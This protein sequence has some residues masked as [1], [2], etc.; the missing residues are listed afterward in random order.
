MAAPSYAPAERPIVPL[1]GRK[2]EARPF[3]LLGQYKGTL[4]LLE[5]PD[6]LYVIDQ[7]VA[8]ER[9]LY[10]R[11]RRSLAK[12]GTPSQ[13]LFTPALLDL[14]PAER[15]RLAELEAAAARVRA[16]EQRKRRRLAAGLAAA[17]EARRRSPE[18]PVTVLERSG[19]ISYGA[20]GLPY[21]FA[22]RIPS[23]EHLVLH[24][25]EYFRESHGVE[26]RLHSEAL[27]IL[28]AKSIV[29]YAER[30]EERE[31]GYDS[32]VIATSKASS[33][34]ATCATAAA[35]SASL[36]LRGRARPSWSGAATLALRWP[37]RSESAA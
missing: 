35:C 9:I 18:L 24:T 29:R 34:S 7:H 25:P 36:S 17:L 32:L 21:V 10:E 14:G 12:R 5:G 27:E 15:L 26:V 8:H 19:D 6:G 23:L 4:I 16:A 1:S 28:P 30:G 37:R 11:L 20:C 13:A 3:R 31:I 2:G 33:S 22:G